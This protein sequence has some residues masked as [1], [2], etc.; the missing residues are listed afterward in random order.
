LIDCKG[1][2]CLKEINPE[3]HPCVYAG[4]EPWVYDEDWGGCVDCQ[5]SYEDQRE[6][7]LEEEFISQEEVE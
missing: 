1:R 3:Q 6:K 7:E 4:G 5:R 2:K